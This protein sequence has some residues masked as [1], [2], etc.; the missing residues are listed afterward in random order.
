MDD[1]V[2]DGTSCLKFLKV[3]NQNF[4]VHGKEILK[5]DPRLNENQIAD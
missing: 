4:P 2:R 3:K 1:H 5:G